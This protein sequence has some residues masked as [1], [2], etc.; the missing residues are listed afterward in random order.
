MANLTFSNDKNKKF[1]EFG[2]DT[3]IEQSDLGISLDHVNE[4]DDIQSLD[5]HVNNLI[6]ASNKYV[7][8]YIAV[9][10]NRKILF[11]DNYMSKFNCC[12]LI[13]KIEKK[14]IYRIAGK[15]LMQLCIFIR[16]FFRLNKLINSE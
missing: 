6:N 16:R 8:F 9:E 7:I 13:N 10:S 14:L 11:D 2:Y 5:N 15:P 1:I 4:C 12:L 3:I